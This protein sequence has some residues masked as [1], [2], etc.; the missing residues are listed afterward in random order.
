MV[1]IP[2]LVLLG[3]SFFGLTQVESKGAKEF[4]DNLHWSIAYTAAAALGWVGWRQSQADDRPA[5]FW[6]ATGL[7]TYAL[8]QWTWDVQ[9]W[10]DWKV[11]PGPSDLLFLT[12]GP[13]LLLGLLLTLRRTVS[14]SLFRTALLDLAT[15]SSAMVVLSLALF[16]PHRNSLPVVKLVSMITYPV[17]LLV[18]VCGLV[19]AVPTLRIRPGWAWITLLACSVLNSLLWLWWNSVYAT[20]EPESGTAI[21]TLFSLVGLATGLGAMGWTSK[22]KD[23]PRWERRC[24]GFLR[25][26]PIIMVVCAATA[27]GVDF[28]V[29]RDTSEIRTVILSGASATLV[30][31]VIRQSLLL[32]ERDRLVEA[33]RLAAENR[34]NFR[35]LFE[36]APDAIFLMKGPVYCD[37][38]PAALAL[39]G[40]TREQVIHQP[41]TLF[42]PELQ[43]DGIHSATKAGRLIQAALNGEPQSFEWRHQKLNG[44]PLDCEVHLNRVAG[45]GEGFIQAF[46]RDVTARKRGERD[47]RESEERFA[48]AF[49]AS[50]AI[51]VILELPSGRFLEVNRAFVSTVGFER[52]E[53]LGRTPTELGLW[54]LGSAS[55]KMAE[56]VLA[57]GKLL[58]LECLVR[59][60]NG[61][62]LTLL[63]STE[64]MDL[65][66][67]PV[68]LL[69]ASDITQRVQ[70]EEQL[71]QAQKLEAIG[72]L[73]GGIAHDFNNILGVITGNA[74]IARLDLNPDHPANQSVEEILTASKRAAN[75]VRQI[76]AF[77]R[78]QPHQSRRIRL[79]KVLAESCRLLRATVPASVEIQVSAPETLPDIIGDE[80]QVQQVLVNLVTNSWHAM[81][82]KPGRIR[83]SA[84]P[85]L[86]GPDDSASH[87]DIPPGPYIRM[88]LSD[89][90]LGMDPE[91]LKR[92]FDPFFT[93]KAPGEGSGLGLSVVHGIVKGHRGSISVQSTPGLGT[94]FQILLPAAI[95]ES[96]SRTTELESF[97]QGSGE[98]ILYVDDELPLVNVATILLGR[99]GYDV[100]GFTNPI[101]AL[102]AIRTTPDA[103]H[104][105]ITDL[106]MP[107]MSGLE[108]AR[109]VLEI[110]PGLPILLS[111]GNL[112]EAPVEQ[113]RLLGIHGVISKPHSLEELALRV[114]ELLTPP[115]H[116]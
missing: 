52:A 61:Q 15:L 82:G 2:T 3:A 44:E 76:L 71:R 67:R 16:L 47:L 54:A 87:G 48:K 92:I 109:R 8:G 31:A 64:R 30:L 115:V 98:K 1:L 34:V 111:S 59:A 58:N 62:G 94:A 105:V 95:A 11:F 27:V 5:R 22:T 113:A 73:S 40:A 38:N 69:V 29:N 84:E 103:C 17:S 101:A 96:E 51:A 99:L 6:F 112:A 50:P 68:V 7:S 57:G 23:S 19:V 83:V 74:H 108:F 26:L 9:V 55:R 33:E 104:A 53:T 37:C 70:L 13:F 75:L 35:T 97:P 100:R 21:N 4:L 24:E 78:P 12:L 86:L 63:A 25:L 107:A 81:S 110:R 36:S 72:L 114:R 14:R 88:T 91:T 65:S 66:G 93:T 56:S 10:V 85:V 106:N 42:S 116:A 18:A 39:F 79:G 43:P 90:G 80:T 60:K 46:V 28:A 32:R 49:D 89:T 20:Q 41:P 45:N 102:D 77:A